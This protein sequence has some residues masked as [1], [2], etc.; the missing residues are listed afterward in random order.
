MEVPARRELPGSIRSR[1]RPPRLGPMSN[2]PILLMCALSV[3]ENWRCSSGGTGLPSASSWSS[4]CWAATRFQATIALVGDEVQAG[5]ADALAVGVAR[6]S[7]PSLPEEQ[8]VVQG[9]A[10][11]R[12]LLSWRHG[13]CPWDETRK[14]APRALGPLPIPIRRGA[15]AIYRF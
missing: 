7:L 2:L 9:V 10:S 3:G 15:A 4:A 13:H 8:E 14:L 12:C 6:R 11:T 5:G 1:S